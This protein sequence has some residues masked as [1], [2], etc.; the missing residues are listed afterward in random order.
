MKVLYIG[1]G[2]INYQKYMNNLRI[3]ELWGID[4]SKTQIDTAK[5]FLKESKAPVHLVESPMEENP[6]LPHA[7]FDIAIESLRWVRRP[8][9]MMSLN[10][11][12]S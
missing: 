9:C 7:Y 11:F 6:G 2:S 1:C 12:L 4:L 8:I 3:S 5:E 10:Y